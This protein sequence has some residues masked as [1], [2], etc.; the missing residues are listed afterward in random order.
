MLNLDVEMCEICNIIR[1]EFECNSLLCDNNFLNICGLLKNCNY[2]KMISK[3]YVFV[4]IGLSCV[5][6]IC[7]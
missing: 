6:K 4:N 2:D 1:D 5:C 7:C 3:F